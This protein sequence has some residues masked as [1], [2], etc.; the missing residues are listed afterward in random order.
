MRV[1]GVPLHPLLVHFPIA[2]WAAVPVLDVA[3]LLAGPEPWWRLAL[4]ASILGIAIGAAAIIVGLL[5]YLQP[6]LAGIDM[7]LAARHGVRATLAWIMFS[8]K[9]IAAALLPLAPWSMALCLALDVIACMLL[10][11]AVYFGTRQVYDQ[12]EK[13]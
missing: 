6:S 8:A 12:L 11:Q 1:F 13:E 9:I 4:G 10:A 2:F 3:A 5:E 7:R